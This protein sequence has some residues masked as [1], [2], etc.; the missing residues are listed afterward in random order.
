MTY[1][2]NKQV[3]SAAALLAVIS[4]AFMALV[5]ISP[6]NHFENSHIIR[7]ACVGNSITEGTE[8]PKDL[9]ALLGAN[10]LVVNC[11]AGGT[12][13]L[14]TS[15]KPYVN[16]LAFRIALD[17]QPN[18]VLIM[19]G[20]NDANPKYYGNVSQF[21]TDYKVIISLFEV[22]H[23]KIWIMKPPPIFDDSLGPKSENLVQG[24]MPRIDQIAHDL[25][26]PTIN[27]YPLLIDHPDYFWDGVHPDW[28]GAKI[29]ADAVYQAAFAPNALSQ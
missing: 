2:E 23:P 24:I 27:I 19:L 21:V 29:I 14:F 26:L 7:V 9:Q 25:N 17:L 1:A 22:F 15:D 6:V 12:T 16:S 8:Y 3:L 11:G 13:A 20:T 5:V 10:Y 28:Q 18:V 4:I